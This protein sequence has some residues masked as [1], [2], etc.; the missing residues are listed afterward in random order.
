MTKIRVRK[1]ETECFSCNCKQE[2]YSPISDFGYEKSLYQCS[3]CSKLIL[4]DL[5]KEDYKKID[6]AKVVSEKKCPEC[7]SPLNS[8]LI[9]YPRNF[10]CDKCKSIEHFDVDANNLS[11]DNVESIIEVYDLYAE[12]TKDGSDK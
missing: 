1:I 8:F 4:R 12:K 6:F 3:K 7:E 5:E 11:T 9:E 2:I 10:V